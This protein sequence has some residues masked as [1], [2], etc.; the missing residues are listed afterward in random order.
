[1]KI[2]A[3]NR[4]YGSDKEELN[5]V[6]QTNASYFVKFSSCS[7]MEKSLRLSKAIL[8]SGGVEMRGCH[9]IRMVA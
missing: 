3:A 9:N 1:M 4:Y 7:D 2:I 5:I 8:K 6:R